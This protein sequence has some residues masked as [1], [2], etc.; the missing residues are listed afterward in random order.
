MSEVNSVASSLTAEL[1]KI[2]NFKDA[3]GNG[4]ID[5]EVEEEN[6][7]GYIEEADLNKDGK[8]LLAETKYYYQTLFF[9]G[10]EDY[11]KDFLLSEAE[12]EILVKE[13]PRIS[14][15]QILARNIS[16]RVIAETTTYHSV[17]IMIGE[18]PNYRVE[19]ATAMAKI[20]LYNDAY[21]FSKTFRDSE[22]RIKTQLAILSSMALSQCQCQAHDKTETFKQMK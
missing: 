18:D 15:E 5:K 20:G 16:M 17:H 3:N 6:D 13:N 1:F 4:S 19:I 9:R 14:F 22:D 12:A 8:I 11:D 2:L 7:E 10:E 21:L